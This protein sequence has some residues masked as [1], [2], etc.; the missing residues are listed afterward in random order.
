MAALAFAHSPTAL[1]SP[2]G[3][4]SAFP[5]LGARWHT[6][7]TCYVQCVF[8]ELAKCFPF[9]RSNIMRLYPHMVMWCSL[10]NLGA[11]NLCLSS[12]KYT[13]KYFYL[14]LQNILFWNN[15]KTP[16]GRTHLYVVIFVET[17]CRGTTFMYLNWRW[18][19]VPCIGKAW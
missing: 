8:I 1:S 5:T 17:P 16:T 12:T 19:V 9:L 15:G 14:K 7:G 18:N 13:T 11:C 2:L 4:R 3:E 6:P 10:L